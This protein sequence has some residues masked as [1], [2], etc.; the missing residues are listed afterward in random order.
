MAPK[1]RKIRARPKSPARTRKKSVKKK[2][3]KRSQGHVGREHPELVGLGL[4]ALGLFLA[5]ILWAGWDGG[6]VGGAIADGFLAAIGWASYTVP[7]ALLAVGSLMVGRSELMQFRPFR[8]G[9]VLAATGLVV[10]LGA[11]HGGWV[12]KTVSHGLALLLGGTGTAIVGATALVF[13]ALLLSGAS[14]GAILRRSGRAVR[15]AATTQKR[16]RHKVV[17]SNSL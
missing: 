5:S 13:G 7:L 1:K 4:V 16:R 11:D 3:R 10:T 14:L 9:E 6:I 12:G 15:S 17:P 8:A 2:T